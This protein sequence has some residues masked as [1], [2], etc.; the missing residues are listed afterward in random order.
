MSLYNKT[1]MLWQQFAFKTS[2][3]L[4]FSIQI[5]KRKGFGYPEFALYIYRHEYL[6]YDVSDNINF[7]IWTGEL[8]SHRTAVDM[9]VSSFA[10]FCIA[11]AEQ[12]MTGAMVTL[13]SWHSVQHCWHPASH[14]PLSWHY[15]DHCL[16]AR[17]SSDNFISSLTV[18]KF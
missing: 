4:N 3:F 2:R 14:C 16:M 6:V 15:C 12:L 1:F 10:M 9:K 13:I 17:E 5:F 18:L 8:I 7:W 11:K